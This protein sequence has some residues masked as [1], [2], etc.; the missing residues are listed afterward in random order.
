MVLIAECGLKVIL[1]EIECDSGKCITCGFPVST[2]R[3]QSSGWVGFFSEELNI[4]EDN[5]H[6]GKCPTGGCLD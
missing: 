2:L 4:P 1:R 5:H 6:L 3:G